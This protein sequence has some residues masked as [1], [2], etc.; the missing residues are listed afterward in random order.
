MNFEFQSSLFLWGLYSWEWGAIY[1]LCFGD[2]WSKSMKKQLGVKV[3]FTQILGGHFTCSVTA[4]T[5]W[6][7][8]D[9][10]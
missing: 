10:A 3:D 6:N 1:L 2:S 9:L 5:L 4:V 8:R 7:G